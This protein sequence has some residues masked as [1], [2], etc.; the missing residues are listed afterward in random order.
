MPT[1]KSGDQLSSLDQ[2]LVEKKV[3]CALRGKTVSKNCYVVV[4]LVIELD[5]GQHLG[6]II[7]K[8]TVIS[9]K[10]NSPCLGIVMSGDILYSINKE[11][12]SDDVNKNK[13]ILAKINQN[14]GKFT[15]NV[16]RFKRRPTIKPLIPKGYTPVEGF[17]Y[18]W[19]MLYLMRGMSLG[20]DVRLIDNKVWNRFMC[21]TSDA[22]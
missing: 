16:I 12:F 7:K 17:E 2:K 19:T 21:L 1:E 3:F 6:L 8:D 14:G 4:P 9:V 10:W 20:L 18:E 15:V 13:E 11:V 5:K 22:V